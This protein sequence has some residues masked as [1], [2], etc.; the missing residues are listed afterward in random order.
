[1]GPHRITVWPNGNA[2]APAL[3][4]F[5]LYR[6]SRRAPSIPRQSERSDGRRRSVPHAIWHYGHAGESLDVQQVV[7]ASPRT[8]PNARIAPQAQTA[9]VDA[10]AG[11]KSWA[12]RRSRLSRIRVPSTPHIIEMSRGIGE[13]VPAAAIDILPPIAAPRR[14]RVHG[15]PPTGYRG[16]P[17]Q[18]IALSRS[19][20]A[21][22][23]TGRD[24][25]HRLRP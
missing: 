1:M 3:R 22:A 20:R 17:P 13:D 25:S 10:M 4:A 19:P 12:R 15:L 9:G 23:S 11:S 21:P 18:E 7:H 2:P 24:F 16:S 14:P 5:L 8:N 6:P